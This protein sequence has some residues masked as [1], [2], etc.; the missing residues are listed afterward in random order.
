MRTNILWATGAL[1]LIAAAPALA[2][3]N[4]G[5]AGGGPGGGQGAGPPMTPPGQMGPS[6]VRGARLTSAAQLAIHAGSLAV[7]LP[8]SSA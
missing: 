5:G 8:S 3:G 1:A 6:A 7:T 4:S 2:Q